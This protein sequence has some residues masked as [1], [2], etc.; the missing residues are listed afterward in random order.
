MKIFFTILTLAAIFY[1]KPMLAFQ[2]LYYMGLQAGIIQIQ[3]R[4]ITQDTIITPSHTIFTDQHHKGITFGSNY[5][6][7]IGNLFIFDP[8]ILAAELRVTLS[9][10]NHTR[11]LLL[12][13][14]DLNEFY[15][16]D[17]V[18]KMNNFYLL[19]IKPGY[20]LP[21]NAILY[22]QFGVGY[23]STKIDTLQ[24]LNTANSIE[25]IQ[26]SQRQKLPTGVFGLG[27][28]LLISPNIAL[29]YDFNFGFLKQL[30]LNKNQNVNG[31]PY[32]SAHQLDQLLFQAILGLKWYSHYEF[33]PTI[34]A[35]LTGWYVGSGLGF[36]QANLTERFLHFTSNQTSFAVE[37][38]SAT[39]SPDVEVKAGR[40]FVL[41]KFV[42]FTEAFAA[43]HPLKAKQNPQINLHI[44][45]DETGLVNEHLR[46]GPTLGVAVK[47]GLHYLNRVFFLTL[48]AG[49]TKL[50]TGHNKSIWPFLYLTGW[51]LETNLAPQLNLR[52]EYQLAFGNRISDTHSGA[53]STKTQKLVQQKGNLSLIYYIV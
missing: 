23:V 31:I 36:M 24:N 28:E 15:T 13:H 2:S 44:S 35:P 32:H 45:P 52:A 12:N 6:A 4:S 29:Y 50:D 3:D 17:H 46:T 39:L 7:I 43:Y 16:L 51:G 30:T 42:F 11:K 19:L 25:G 22:T 1:A 10:F 33:K 21:S 53:M 48:G 49:T 26:F 5:G 14:F 9:E 20:L 34:N 37:N 18:T 41:G 38:R 47:P 27:L 8:W 40:N